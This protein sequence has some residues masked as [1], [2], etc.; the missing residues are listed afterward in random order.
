MR[1]CASTCM[2]QAIS[3]AAAAYLELLRGE[4]W[5]CQVD[6][7]TVTAVA[8]SGQGMQ[9]PAHCVR[10]SH[11]VAHSAQ[12]ML[13]CKELAPLTQSKSSAMNESNLPIRPIAAR[14]YRRASSALR[15]QSSTGNLLQQWEAQESSRGSVTC[16]LLHKVISVLPVHP[17]QHLCLARDSCIGI[18]CHSSTALPLDVSDVRLQ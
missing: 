1:K 6:A 2:K 15:H 14:T 3:A 10:P 8:F 11:L 18:Y 16:V 12:Q 4:L 17:D 7:N 9:L 13:P 5:H